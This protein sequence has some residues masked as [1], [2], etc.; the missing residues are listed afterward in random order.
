M[1]TTART[2]EINYYRDCDMRI[3]AAWNAYHDV[4]DQIRAAAKQIAKNVEMIN[5]YT[6]RPVSQLRYVDMNVKLEKKIN[7]LRP[8]ADRLRTAAVDL[9]KELYTGWTRFFLVKHIHRSTHCSSFRPT[10]RVGW[11]PQVSGLTEAEAVAEN[12]ETLCTICYPSAPTALT[13]KQA[14]PSLCSGSGK[15]HSTEHLTGRE[16]SYSY[17]AGYCPDCLRWNTL[18]KTGVMRKHKVD[19]TRRHAIESMK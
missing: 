5:Y 15:F 8:E 2:A 9:D 17:A 16:N 1:T 4:N 11:L 3:S 6:N 13:T 7:D 10:T 14:D 12:G 19:T 18:T